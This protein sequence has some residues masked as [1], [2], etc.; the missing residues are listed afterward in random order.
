MG[1]LFLAT[2]VLMLMAAVW[3]ERRLVLAALVT[4]LLFAVP[5]T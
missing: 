5:H 1:A 4:W 2:G 3:L